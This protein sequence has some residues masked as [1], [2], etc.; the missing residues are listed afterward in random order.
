MLEYVDNNI[1]YAVDF[2]REK[3]PLIRVYKPEATYMVWLDFSAYGLSDAELM[4][5]IINGAGLGLSPGIMFGPGGEGCMRIN[6]A[7]P[8]VTV[9]LALEKLYACF[10]EL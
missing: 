4:H 5:I 6:L 8:Q 3:L 9:K 2:L 10:S 1:G 7:C